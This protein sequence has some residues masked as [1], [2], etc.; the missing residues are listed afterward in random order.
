MIPKKLADIFTEFDEDDFDLYITRV[1]FSSDNFIIDFSIDV[2]NINQTGSIQQKWKVEAAGHRKNH[3]SLNQS[4]FLII[5]D[6]HPLL[7]EFTDLQSQ[8]YFTGICKDQAKL[9]YDLYV[10]HEKLFG[11]HRCFE[12]SFG[13]VSSFPKPFQYS[14]G[15]LAQGSKKLMEKYSDCLIQNGLDFKI[16]DDRPAMYGNDEQFME[17]ETSLKVL[18]SGDSYII[19]NDFFFELQEENGR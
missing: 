8:L 17:E 10:T 13:K 3:V 12:I 4:N 6:D 2:Q 16:I 19:A 5:N 9:F 1:D 18:I 14:N 11:K 15:L 7:W